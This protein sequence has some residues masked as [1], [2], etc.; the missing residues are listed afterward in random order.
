[1]QVFLHNCL[2]E[3]APA[4]S[5][6]DEDA[7]A[8]PFLAPASTTWS[9]ATRRAITSTRRTFMAS[10]KASSI[11]VCRFEAPGSKAGHLTV[12]RGAGH[13]PCQ[14]WPTR[15]ATS[16]LAERLT[17]RPS[18]ASLT[19]K[20]ALPHAC[21]LCKAATPASASNPRTNISTRHTTWWKKSST[22][23][24]WPRASTPPSLRR[25]PAGATESSPR[26]PGPPVEN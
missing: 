15:A 19:L 4:S 25:G 5:E 12:R 20:P 23:V 14:V 11:A 17:R 21:T 22:A 24:G 26:H 13:P 1:M 3:R 18:A 10:W 9:L 7:R 2:Y 16:S 6:I 8:E